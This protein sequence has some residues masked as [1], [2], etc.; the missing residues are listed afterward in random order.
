MITPEE[1]NFM[2]YWELNRDRQKRTLRQ[3][4]L[5]IPV[6]LLFAI[7]ILVNFFSGWY[8]RA[9][10]VANTQEFNPLP[11]IIALIGIVC[12]V[13]IFTKRHQWE[14]NEQRYQELK[15]KKLGPSRDQEKE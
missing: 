12:F 14:M 11:L 5:G 4:L 9:A 8:K 6:G 2:Q 13:A 7:L 15:A 1:E 10:M 3:F